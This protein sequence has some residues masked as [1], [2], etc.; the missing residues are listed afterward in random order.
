[1]DNVKPEPCRVWELVP[2]NV[3][4]AAPQQSSSLGTQRNCSAAPPYQER[5]GNHCCT[6]SHVAS[7]PNDDGYGKTVVEVTTVTT[8]KKY[9]VEE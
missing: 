5:A 6:C 7:E 2:V 3:D 9:R 8:R 1:M 4:G